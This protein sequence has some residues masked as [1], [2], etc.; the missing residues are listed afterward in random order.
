[1]T[2]TVLEE[3]SFSD[4]FHISYQTLVAIHPFPLFR[5][6]RLL[7]F[8][9][10]AHASNRWN[11]H[12]PVKGAG[13]N[14]ISSSRNDTHGNCIVALQKMR[15]KRRCRICC[16]WRIGNGFC[17]SERR[18]WYRRSRKKDTVKFRKSAFPLIPFLWRL[19]SFIEGVLNSQSRSKLQTTRPYFHAVSK[20]SRT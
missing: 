15:W 7:C 20:N 8:E 2:D 10:T 5:F 16:Q 9:H 13:T 1:M 18:C 12:C 3:W 14:R 19:G 4:G 6:G 17:C 11:G